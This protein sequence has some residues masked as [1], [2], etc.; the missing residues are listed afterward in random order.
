MNTRVHAD[1]VCFNSFLLCLI[2]TVKR[3]VGCEECPGNCFCFF[4][5]RKGYGGVLLLIYLE[6]AL[7]WG[8]LSTFL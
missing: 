5:G 4:I 3:D 7:F 8:C 6:A 1:A 2:P